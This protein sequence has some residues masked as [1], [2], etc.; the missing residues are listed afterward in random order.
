MSNWVLARSLACKAAA[1]KGLRT[2]TFCHALAVAASAQAC[3]EWRDLK[4]WRH[5]SASRPGRPAA[6]ECHPVREP[7]D[8][9]QRYRDS[10]ISTVSLVMTD[11]PARVAKR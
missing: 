3:V 9:G 11:A 10:A 8:E 2:R 4:V 5:G 7:C 6:K 1:V